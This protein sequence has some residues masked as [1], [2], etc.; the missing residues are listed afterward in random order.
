MTDPELVPGDLMTAARVC[1][2]TLTPA[3]DRDWSVRR[4]TW[5]GI[6]G[7]PST[8]SSIRSSST[9]PTWPAEGASASLRHA[10]A[11]HLRRRR[12]SW[13]PLARPRPC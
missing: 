2:E 7:A 6:A 11:T 13:R 1:R 3:L 10:T 8:T 12:S 4:A 5:S 9:R